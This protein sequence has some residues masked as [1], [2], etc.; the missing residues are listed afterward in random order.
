M[1]YAAY[2]AQADL[3]DPVR[4]AAR[5][6]RRALGT[7]LNGFGETAFMRN[8][9][10]AL[11]MVER[12]GLS[13]ARPSFGVDRVPVGNREV[14]VIE[15]VAL[16]LPFGSLLHFAKDVDQPQPR[17]LVVAPLSGHF[18]TLLQDTVRT[19]LP[20]NDVY[21]TDWANARDVPLSAGRFGFDDYVEHVIR[22]M[23]AI[24]P[25]GHVLAVCQP[26]VQVLTAAAVMAQHDNPAQPL[27]M[28]LMAG[29][30]DTRV[31]PTKVN[32]LATSKPLDWFEKNL[33]ATVPAG[34][35][36]AGRRVYPGFVQV[37]AFMAMNMER[38]VKAHV[39]LF[40]NLAMG[41]HEKAHATKS[42]YDEYFAV[43]DLAAEFYLETIAKVF[44]EH[45]LPRGVL[46]YKG[47]KVDFRA[48]RRTALLTVEGERDDICAVGQTV[49]AQDICTSLRPH[50]RRHHM[51]AGVGHYGVFS[52]RRWKGQVYPLVRSHV[53]ASDA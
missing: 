45:E 22:F 23:E 53:L 12:A 41:E 11:E 15:E 21:V 38:H 8:F 39:E 2:Q 17:I 5:F 10:A 30:V 18:A 24:G 42:F 35:A 43:L 14:E 46:T 29:P 34:F 48:I 37:G 1:I 3:F 20:E 13:H 47:E 6:T 4:M 28:T 33:I 50:L 19:L 31:S 7:S 16:E 40:E 27:S 49:A 25:G 26:C 51:Q 9:T 52:G 32:E 36:G 44:Q